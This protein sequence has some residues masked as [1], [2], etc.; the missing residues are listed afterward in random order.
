MK[1][2]DWRR[3]VFQSA[4]FSIIA[5]GIPL[6]ALIFHF[7]PLQPI[8]AKG[9]PVTAVLQVSNNLLIAQV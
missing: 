2:V 8:N 6:I 9:F 7:N 4:A 5:I 1:N 3:V